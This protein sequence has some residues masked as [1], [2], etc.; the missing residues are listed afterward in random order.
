MKDDHLRELGLAAFDLPPAALGCDDCLAQ[1]SAFVERELAGLPR[2][3]AHARV[4]A[5]LE[6]CGECQEEFEA[7]LAALDPSHT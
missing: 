6:D 4:A 2:I 1:V 5:H 3:E 7:L